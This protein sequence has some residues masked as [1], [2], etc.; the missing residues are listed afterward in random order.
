M[1]VLEQA[2]TPV[3]QDHWSNQ[4]DARIEIWKSAETPQLRTAR[5]EKLRVINA[6]VGFQSLSLPRNNFYK[7]RRLASGK[8]IQNQP[9]TNSVLNPRSR[10]L[11]RQTAP[12]REF[13]ASARR[14]AVQSFARE[15]RCLLG[16]FARSQAG[17]EHFVRCNWRSETNRKPTLSGLWITLA[18]VRPSMRCALSLVIREWCNYYRYAIAKRTFCAL[19]DHVWRI[20]YRWAKRRHPNKTRHWVVNRYFGVDR[21]GR[22]GPVRRPAPASAPQRNQSVPLREGQGQ[23]QSLRSE[24]ARLLGGSPAAAIGAGSGTLQSRSPAQAAGG[25]VRG[26]QGG[27]RRR[28]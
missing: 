8:T 23:S 10:E 7:V 4:R 15:R 21:G 13:R 6:R 25:P 24:P 22:L 12:G 27:L 11:W 9:L 14:A 19:D 26:L 5:I 17:R 20:T 2:P 1:C 3:A 28:P 18:A 16:I